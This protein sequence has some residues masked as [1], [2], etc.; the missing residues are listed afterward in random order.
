MSTRFLT[1]C[2]KFRGNDPTPYSWLSRNLDTDGEFDRAG[3]Y[4]IRT[5]EIQLLPE[6]SNMCLHPRSVDPVPEQTA[7]VARAAFPKGTIYMTMKDTLGEV[8]E[9]EDF[10]NLFPSRGQPAMAPWRL[11]L[12][13]IMQFAEGLSDRQAA[14]AVRGRIDCKYALSLE[15]DDPGF[16]ASVLSEFRSRLLDGGSER[17]LFDHLLDRYRE[18]GLVKERG[19]QRTDSTRILAVVRGLNRLELVG[20][21]MRHAL[22][23]LA[24][25]APQWLRGRVREQWTQRYIHRV[26]EEKLPKSKEARQ[27]EGEKI[28]ADGRELLDAIYSEEAPSWLKEVPAV[29]TL[30]KVWVQ[31]YFREQ[32]GTTKWRTSEIGIPRSARF[33]ASP[34]DL[35]ARYARKFTS[36]WVGY[37][38]HITETCEDD[39]PNIITDVQTTLGP[40]ADGDATAPIHEALKEKDLLPERQFVDTG[41]LDAELLAES[42]QN[43]GVD[44]YGPTRPDYKW[45]AREKSGFEAAAFTIDWNN[46][47]ATCPEGKKSISWT[48]AIDKQHNKV[49]KVKF[50]GKDCMPCPSRDLCI[51]SVK[52]YKRRTVTIRRPKEHHEALQSARERERTE[53]FKAQ[54]TR[55]AGIEGTISRAV[56]TC[57]VRRS[58]YIGQSKTHLHHLLSSTSLSFLRVGEWLS[59]VSK[60]NTRRSPFARLMAPAI[61]A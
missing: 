46:E 19:K 60:P 12:A 52:D 10:A 24:A 33:I 53:E 55:R 21:T 41:Y 11:A 17:L 31:N 6:A 4:W 30:R 2:Q 23:V 38:V 35:D 50:S 15:L 47:I 34:F 32:D 5:P 61:A 39:L 51:R 49:M 57:E 58:R 28:G 9:D 14:D 48:P 45:Q 25:V 8:F 13:T 27:V 3:A 56:R 37:K 7:R 44:L 18:M 20:E 43:Y 26:D 16:D 42:K 54:Y 29:E 59:D 36:S 22:D 40:I 1:P